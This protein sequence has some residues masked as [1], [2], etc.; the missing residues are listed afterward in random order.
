MTMSLLSQ[1]STWLSMRESPSKCLLPRTTE[2]S[3]HMAH[4]QRG[5]VAI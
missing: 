3:S 4:F 2:V 5:R 1:M